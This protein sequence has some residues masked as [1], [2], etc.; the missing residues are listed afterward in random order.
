MMG[1]IGDCTK[2]QLDTKNA[3][4]FYSENPDKKSS[5]VIKTIVVQS[6]KKSK[7]KKGD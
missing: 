5:L 2:L 3:I 4:R 1:F 7:M 6:Y